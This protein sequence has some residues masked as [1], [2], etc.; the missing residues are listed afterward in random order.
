MYGRNHAL[1]SLSKGKEGRVEI[2]ISSI[3]RVIDTLW[4][5]PLIQPT[6]L[7]NIKDAH[8]PRCEFFIFLIAN[9]PCKNHAKKDS[10]TF[11]RKQKEKSP[12]KITD[13]FTIL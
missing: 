8:C 12:E 13:D 7:S 10:L 2:A 6:L 11:F 1:L 5:N 9:H 3:I 4:Y